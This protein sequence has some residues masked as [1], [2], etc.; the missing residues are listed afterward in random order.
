[1]DNQKW[2]ININTDITIDFEVP[3]DVAEMMRR[4]DSIFINV[5]L[6]SREFTL[7][8]AGKDCESYYYHECDFKWYRDELGL[9]IFKHMEAGRM[10]DEQRT[11]L[12]NRYY[13]D[14]EEDLNG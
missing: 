13:P 3:E 1:M 11:I 7:Y 12:R 4:L 6:P 10:T 14:F 5:E 2:I 9:R 8:G